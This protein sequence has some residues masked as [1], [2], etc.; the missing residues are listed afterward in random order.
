M[1]IIIQ[2]GNKQTIIYTD[3]QENIV[4][5]AIP[6]SYAFNPP[7]QY[8]N[9]TYYNGDVIPPITYNVTRQ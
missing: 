5:P 1:K 9:T 8:D 4:V 2:Q 6:S 7:Y 3:E